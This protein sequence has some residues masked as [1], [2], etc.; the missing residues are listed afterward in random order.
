MKWYIIS[1]Q[2]ILFHY[3]NFMSAYIRWW[4]HRSE[5]LHSS[6]HALRWP[7]ETIWWASLQLVYN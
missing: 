5:W 6:I 7:H 1:N 4:L 3:E 2:Q